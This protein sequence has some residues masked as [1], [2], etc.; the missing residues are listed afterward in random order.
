TR[1]IVLRMLIAVLAPGELLDLP[2]GGRRLICAKEIGNRTQIDLKAAVD[3]NCRAGGGIAI[4][5][6]SEPREPGRT[7]RPIEQRAGRRGQ[8]NVRR[9]IQRSQY[10]RNVSQIVVKV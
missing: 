1:L 8:R 6:V 9:A 10:R 7:L 5:A 2:V 3:G 4:K